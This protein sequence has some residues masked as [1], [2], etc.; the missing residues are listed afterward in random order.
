MENYDDLY[1]GVRMRMKNKYGKVLFKLK[2]LS[3]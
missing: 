2:M 3:R 1:H